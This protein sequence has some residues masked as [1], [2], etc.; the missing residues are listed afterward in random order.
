MI[1]YEG[2]TWPLGEYDLCSHTW[3]VQHV[4]IVGSFLFI[5][6]NLIKSEMSHDHHFKS[7]DC[8]YVY[9]YLICCSYELKSFTSTNVLWERE[10]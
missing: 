6:E 3:I 10:A 9:T 7:H 8:S 5:L 1:R 2:G 4:V